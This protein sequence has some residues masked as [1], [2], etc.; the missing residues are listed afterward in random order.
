MHFLAVTASRRRHTNFHRRVIIPGRCNLQHV[1]RGNEVS[2]KPVL[3]I[4]LA[5]RDDTPLPLAPW[6]L[7]HAVLQ[8]RET[9]RTTP[10][11]G[12]NFR[13]PIRHTPRECRL[14]EQVRLLLWLRTS[15][16]WLRETRSLAPV[17]HRNSVAL[18]FDVLVDERDHTLWLL[19]MIVDVHADWSH[20]TT[21]GAVV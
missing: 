10:R 2:K 19:G 18:T 15:D 17:P 21:G 9:F 3:S 6:R 14:S 7:E 11:A 12:F 13:G 16:A 8:K 1:L 20:G 5:R 4:R